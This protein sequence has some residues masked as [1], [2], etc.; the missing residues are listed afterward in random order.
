MNYNRPD[1]MCYCD[2]RIAEKKIKVE[3]IVEC[4]GCKEEHSENCYL[5]DYELFYPDQLCENCLFEKHKKNWSK[6]KK[7]DS[8]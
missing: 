1:G 4:I 8:V 5:I 7:N 3:D 6:K 2:I